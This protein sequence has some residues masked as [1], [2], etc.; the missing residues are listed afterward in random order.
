MSDPSKKAS[1]NP[2]SSPGVVK[3]VKFI[4]EK[5]S[6][7]RIFH[8][9]EVWATISSL[10]N[11]QIDF[12]VQHPVVPPFVIHPLNPDGSPTGEQ[13]MHGIDDPD[14]TV[15]VRDFQCGVVF[16]LNTAIQLQHALDY[17]IK[18]TKQQMDA[19]IGQIKKTP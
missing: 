11:V 17:Y 6:Q 3:P 5:G 1:L 19:A 12:C 7:Y 14:Y 10:G 18:S 9:D 8:A 16:S 15:V 4:H 2:S 13:K